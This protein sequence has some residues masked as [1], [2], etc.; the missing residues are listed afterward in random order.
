MLN[1]EVLHCES[2]LVR[3]ERL[4]HNQL[5]ESVQ[6]GVPFTW[7]RLILRLSRVK[8]LL[9]LQVIG[10]KVCVNVFKGRQD[11][12]HSDKLL[13]SLSPSEIIKPLSGVLL[14]LDLSRWTSQEE[15]QLLR[16]HLIKTIKDVDCHLE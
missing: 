4:Y 12:R 2:D 15:S 1:D 9:E 14:D 16:I 7:E 13:G 6:F 10:N 3:S 5:L 11:L 8:D